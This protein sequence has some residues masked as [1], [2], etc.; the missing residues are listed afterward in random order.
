M[1]MLDIILN[2]EEQGKKM[3]Y[4]MACCNGLPESGEGSLIKRGGGDIV[5]SLTCSV[6]Q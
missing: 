1:F 5:I 4:N 2:R 6:A 3:K